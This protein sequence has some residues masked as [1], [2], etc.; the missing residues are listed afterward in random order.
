MKAWGIGGLD[1]ATAQA[2]A[3]ARV[4]AAAAISDPVKAAGI[5]LGAPS[6]VEGSIPSLPADIVACLDDQASVLGPRKGVLA[7]WLQD[8]ARV[9]AAAQS[10]SDALLRDD[11]ASAASVGSWAA[12]TPATPYAVGVDPGAARNWVGG[13][14]PA[15]LGDDVVTSAVLVGDPVSGAVTGIELDAW[16]E[17]VPNATG[18]G[19]V[20]AN[21]VA[22]SARAPNLILLAV[23]PDIS[24]PWTTDALLSV[25]DEALELAQCRLV[26]LDAAQRVPAL[27]PAIYL[28]EYSDSD[29]DIH[30]LLGTAKQ[31]PMRWVAQGQT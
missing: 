26:D 25:V 10:L 7:R 14:F 4:A 30:R 21:L 19:A 20:T 5:L 2:T 13:K 12:Q 24:K 9:R 3:S 23:P 16:T 17:V 28:D 15:P 11:L 27:L 6:V 29:L 8:T 1:D 22:P 31:F 18:T